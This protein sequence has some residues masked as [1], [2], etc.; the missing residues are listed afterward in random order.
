MN[1]ARF[2]RQHKTNIIFGF[3][4]LIAIAL[5]SGDIG[6]NMQ[7]ING[8]KQAIASNSERQSLLEQQFQFEQEQAKIA[9]GRYS[10]GCLPVVAPN[11]QYVAIEAG[12]VIKDR[13]TK[14]RLPTNTVVCDAQG[15]TGV[16]QQ[17]GTVGAIAFT[18][19]RDF[20]AKRLKRFRAGTYSQPI[21]EEQ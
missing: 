21:L 20:V 2:W 4:T 1:S 7:S 3:G 19:D 17:D 8:I 13:I 12:T 14:K 18:G 6:R 10:K 11:R 9:E 5:S 16:I 15:N